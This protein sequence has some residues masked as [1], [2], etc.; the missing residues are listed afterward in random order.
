MTTKPLHY[1]TDVTPDDVNALTRFVMDRL[2]HHP[3]PTLKV[4]T[5][6]Y[7]TNAA[8]RTVVPGFAGSLS[9]EFRDE[10]V[11]EA[12]ADD[13]KG[14]ERIQKISGTWN[15]LVAV[16]SQWRDVEG[17]DTARWCKV[18]FY[19]AQDEEDFRRWEE[20]E[21]AS[22]A[23]TAAFVSEYRIPGPRDG[24]QPAGEFIVVRDPD[25]ADRWAVFEGSSQG[26]HWDGT[27]WQHARFTGAS[28]Y[29]FGRATALATA[30]QH[31]GRDVAD[32]ETSQSR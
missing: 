3:R 28:P 24:G 18:R 26:R 25:N 7:R 13:R 14:L 5:E 32:R 2:I 29:L 1:A 11:A 10:V 20:K 23:E 31:A 30:H 6:E 22:A 16:A 4:G 15:D 27:A 21:K 17:F 9:H 19:H 12:Q 8:L